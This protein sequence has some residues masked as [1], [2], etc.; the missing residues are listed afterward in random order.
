[1]RA[2]DQMDK[3]QQRR[4]ERGEEWRRPGEH[5][6]CYCRHSVNLRPNANQRR[7]IPNDDDEEDEEDDDDAND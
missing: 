7:R 4:P 1:M 6:W 5:N 2:D 3:R